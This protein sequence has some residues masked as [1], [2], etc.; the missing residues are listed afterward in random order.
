MS[1]QHRA[2]GAVWLGTELPGTH[3]G[4]PGTATHSPL[5]H[6]ASVFVQNTPLLKY[7]L[8]Q[9]ACQDSHFSCSICYSKCLVAWSSIT[10]KPCRVE[11]RAG[12][13]LAAVFVMSSRPEVVAGLRWAH[14]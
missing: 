12:R 1:Q 8:K 6:G 13:L 5:P 10:C 7:P 9:Q 4:V 11:P 3:A 2:K 14:V